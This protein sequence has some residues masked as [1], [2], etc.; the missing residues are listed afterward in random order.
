MKQ[1]CLAFNTYARA[2]VRIRSGVQVGIVQTY[3]ARMCVCVYALDC[4][5]FLFRVIFFEYTH[6]FNNKQHTNGDKH[7]DVPMYRLLMK[8]NT[9]TFYVSWYFFVVAATA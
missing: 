2:C 3:R 7:G 5:D 4:F 9:Q 1:R 8:M 6:G